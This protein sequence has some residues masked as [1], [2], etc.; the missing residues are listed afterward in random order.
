ME[1]VV[2]SIT[3]AVGNI[4]S[5]GVS[6]KYPIPLKVALAASSLIDP[7]FEISGQLFFIPKIAIE[8]NLTSNEFILKVKENRHPF[9]LYKEFGVPIVISTDDA[10]ILRTNLTEQYV[11]L[12]KRYPQVSYKDIKEYVYNSI[13]FSFIEESKVK[14]QVL[15]DLDYRFKKFE[16]QFK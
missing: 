12:A 4:I 11:L 1:D 6:Y 5:Q 3:I 13:R 16:A 15:D 7:Y 9:T 14:E 2:K 8:I 10:G